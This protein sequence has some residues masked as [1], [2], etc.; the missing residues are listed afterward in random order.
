[1]LGA[2]THAPKLTVGASFLILWKFTDLAGMRSGQKERRAGFFNEDHRFRKSTSL[3]SGF[4]LESPI[5]PLEQESLESERPFS[6][7]ITH[8][9][10]SRFAMKAIVNGR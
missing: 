6:A 9:K 3:V 2:T 4:E 7:R 5:D 10:Q 8:H 1:M